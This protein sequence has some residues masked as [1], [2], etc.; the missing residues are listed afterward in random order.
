MR[1]EGFK[2][3]WQWQ[4]EGGDY[5]RQPQYNAFEAG[6]DAMLE[7]LKKDPMVLLHIRHKGNAEFER[8]MQDYY[9]E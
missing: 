6:A 5:C 4:E 9:N 1:P 2:N 3:P 7:G 8:L